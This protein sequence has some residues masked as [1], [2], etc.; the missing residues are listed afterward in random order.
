MAEDKVELILNKHQARVLL[1]G[2]NSYEMMYQ[3][4]KVLNEEE[5]ALVKELRFELEYIL[6]RLTS[7]C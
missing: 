6:N 3:S 2:L 7:C 4:T 5:Q 1:C